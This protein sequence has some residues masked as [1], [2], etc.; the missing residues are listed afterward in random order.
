MFSFLAVTISAP[1]ELARTLQSNQSG[2]GEN[3]R[4]VLGVIRS[5]VQNE[6]ISALFKGY[7]STIL[8]DVPYS[9]IYW[10]MF[11]SLKPKYQDILFAQGNQ[12][13]HAISFLSGKHSQVFSTI[14]E[15]SCLS[16]FYF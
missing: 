10:S 5:V 8:R 12:N 1:I 14:I 11:E 3:Q 6:G 13:L 15:N 4:G 16:L 9:A 7:H 2:A